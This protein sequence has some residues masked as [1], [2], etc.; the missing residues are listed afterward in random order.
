MK[1]RRIFGVLFALCLVVSVM[2]L[3]AS[4]KTVASGSCGNKGDNVKWVLDDKGV[5]T[6][7]GTGKMKDYEGSAPWSKYTVKKVVIKDGVTHLGSSAFFL[8]DDLISVSFP[9]TLKSIG[10]SAF[11]GVDGLT[12]I[13]IPDS[14]TEIGSSAFSWCVNLKSVQLPDGLEVLSDSLFMGCKSLKSVKIPSSVEYIGPFAFENCHSLESITLPAKLS[15][16][17]SGV[18]QSCKSLKKIV[19]PAA[20]TSIGPDAFGCC[21]SLAEIIFLGDAPSFWSGAFAD[22]PAVI[23]YPKGNATWNEDTMCGVHEGTDIGN[24][25]WKAYT[26]NPL[27]ITAQPKTVYAK[28]GGKATVTVKATGDGLKYTWYMKNKGETKYTKSSVTKSTYSVTMSSKSKDRMVYC[29]VTDRYGREVKTNTASLRMKATVT[30]QP[31]HA[32]AAIGSTAKT[33]VTAVGD[34]LTYTW[35]FKAKGA[36]SFKKSSVTSATY[37]VKMS[38]TNDGRQAYCVVKDKYG[39]KIK[40]NTVTFGIPVKITTQPKTVTTAKNKTAK[41]TVKADGDGLKY[42]WYVKNKGA[43]KYTKSSVTKSTYSVKMTSKV[44]GRLVY[45]KV[46]DKYGNTVKTKTVSMKMK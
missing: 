10:S 26:L 44:N 13:D 1:L 4:A 20:V 14:V 23:Y 8:T 5:L 3:S 28:S 40:S 21:E 36:S 18:F 41:V 35:Y 7:S 32:S 15:E 11:H 16:I 27:A 33:K 39:N 30:A 31:K 25:T 38:K 34:G 29:K 43:S 24:V 2:A 12:D 17:K 42:T 6:V 22:T 46:T 45:C 37:S 19:I 9:D